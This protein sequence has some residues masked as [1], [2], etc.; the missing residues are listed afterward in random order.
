MKKKKSTK[1]EMTLV[2][3]ELVDENGRNRSENQQMNRNTHVQVGLRGLSRWSEMV[4]IDGD[5][6]Y[7][8]KKQ[9]LPWHQL[10]RG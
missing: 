3:Y 9:I 4:F 5:F 7:D 2:N 1:E 10:V 8:G 6:S